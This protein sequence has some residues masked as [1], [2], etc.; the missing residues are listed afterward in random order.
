MP[1]EDVRIEPPTLQSTQFGPYPTA[2]LTAT[3]PRLSICSARSA[4]S[5]HLSQHEVDQKPWKYIGYK[6]YCDFIAS[7]NDFF[8]VRRF[9]AVSVRIALRLQDQVTIL[10]DRLKKL[11]KAYSRREA[12]DVNSGTLRDEADDR[13]KVLDEL[14]E[15]LVEFSVWLFSSSPLPFPLYT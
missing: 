7:E 2:A 10:E 11:D 6:G 4:D 9:S 5:Q 1:S 13:L 14:K 12:D 8:V 15:K 3:A